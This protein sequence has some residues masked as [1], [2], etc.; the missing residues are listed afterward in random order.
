MTPYMCILTLIRILQSH[1]LR[2]QI[3]PSLVTGAL[4]AAKDYPVT[5]FY[6]NA[7]VLVDIRIVE[8]YRQFIH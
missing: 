2:M 7:F 4:G 8:N 5:A 6:T 1:L 3:N